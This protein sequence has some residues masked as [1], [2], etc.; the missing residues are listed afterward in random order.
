MFADT[1]TGDFLPPQIIY[2]GKTAKCLPMVPFPVNWQVTYTP[3]H[4]ANEK[5][6]EDYINKILV[7]YIEEKRASSGIDSPALVIF[8]RFRGQCTPHIMS[9]LESKNILIA[10]VP[11]NC[12]DKVATIGC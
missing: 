4:W 12:T 5:T 11:A 6:T 2:K 1:L 3:N 10:I 8:D 7:P 9:L